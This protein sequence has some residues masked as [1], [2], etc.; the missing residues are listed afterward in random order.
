MTVR[1]VA[2]RTVAV[3]C[4]AAILGL[5]GSSCIGPRSGPESLPSPP[6]GSDDGAVSSPSNSEIGELDASVAA[7]GASFPDAF[8]QAVGTDFNAL[9]GRELVSYAKSGSSDGR[10]QLAAGTLDLGGSDSLP[11]PTE[12]WPSPPLLFPTVAAPIT[13]SYNLDGVDGLRLDQETLARIFQ[14]DITQ[15]D[16][17]AI[18]AT[19]PGV[20]LPSH[21]ITVVHRS[22]G[23]GTTNN[24]TTYMAKAAPGVWTLGSGDTVNWPEGTQGAEK[25]SGVAAVISQTAG[26]IGYVDLSDAVKADLDLA[27]IR[28]RDGRFVGPT[29]KGTASAVDNAEIADDLSYDPLDAPGVDTYPIT[30]P[31]YLLVLADQP[32]ADIAATIRTYLRYLLS[33]GQDQALPLGYVPLSD[34]LRERA[35]NQVD[36]IRG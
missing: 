31:T 13:V 7:G 14:A 9:A 20:D 2:G 15:W 10:Q 17:P 26:S 16:D 29:A 6:K 28:N 36:R 24:F 30:A 33:T 19:N 3:V 1:A 35:Y 25:N 8:Y 27:S 32:N 5:V 22:D 11:K 34:E 21:R 12:T 18:A 4:T 23:S